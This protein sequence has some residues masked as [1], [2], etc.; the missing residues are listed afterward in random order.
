[1]ADSRRARGGFRT[2][3][4]DGADAFQVGVDTT[5]C[6]DISTVLQGLSRS[7]LG[8]IARA[9]RSPTIQHVVSN[10]QVAIRGFRLL[11][12]E[13]FRIAAF[14]VIGYGKRLEAL[15]YIQNHPV[16][17]SKHRIKKSL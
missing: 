8:K 14:F 1:V 12:V 4:I 15:Q 6:I 17:V 7:R 16:S 11:V 9:T 10:L 5:D 2:V 13:P 3:H